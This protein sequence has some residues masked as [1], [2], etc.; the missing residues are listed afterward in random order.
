MS[1][2]TK[3]QDFLSHLTVLLVEDDP[4]SREATAEFLARR[5]GCLLQ[6][7]NGIE[8]LAL[9]SEMRPPIVVTDISMPFM[10]GLTMAS[11]M[12]AIEPT[13]QIL[14]ITAFGQTDQIKKA[15]EMGVNGYVIKPLQADLLET[16]LLRCARELRLS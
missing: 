9:F 11:Q 6:A 8:G 2:I 15:L 16:T 5:V 1:P 13:V 3:D 10:D 7:A 12:R 14:A 4:E